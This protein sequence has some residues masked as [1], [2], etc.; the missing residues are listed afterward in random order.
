[1]GYTLSRIWSW[2]RNQ[3]VGY[4]KWKK[5]DN[6]NILKLQKCFIWLLFFKTILRK[7]TS[8]IFIENFWMKMEAHLISSQSY[9]TR[10][11][12]PRT[13]IRGLSCENRRHSSTFALERGRGL[14]FFVEDMQNGAIWGH[15]KVSYNIESSTISMNLIDK[16]FLKLSKI[17]PSCLSRY[18]HLHCF[19]QVHF[20]IS[21]NIC[22]NPRKDSMSFFMVDLT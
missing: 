5:G 13:R 9:R 18:E 2:L 12:I 17:C 4:Y 20:K 10:L 16:N 7:R 15:F 11:F 14:G 19:V 3:I 1:M 21:V 6:M 8:H 22:I